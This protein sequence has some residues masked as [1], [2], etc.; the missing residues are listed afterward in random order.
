MLK[1]YTTIAEEVTKN[2]LQAH[3]YALKQH[4]LY[5]REAFVSSLMGFI[6]TQI[7]RGRYV[8]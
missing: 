4:R 3:E 8:K 1:G 6:S 5:E 7:R 2:C